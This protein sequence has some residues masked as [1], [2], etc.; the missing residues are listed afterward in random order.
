MRNKQFTRDVIDTLGHRIRE[1]VLPVP[2]DM[3]VRSAV[4]K[5][6]YR[7]CEK[8]VSLRAELA[9]PTLYRKEMCEMA[10]RLALLGLK[11]EEIAEGI[12]IDVNTL[13]NWKVNH[14]EFFVSVRGR[15]GISAVSARRAECPR[16][17]SP[18]RA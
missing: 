2:Q 7:A 18:A 14:P 15:G 13:E 17:W 16:T 1:V 3:K 8:R 11:D 9:R 4:G 10:R 5:F 6:V 12:N